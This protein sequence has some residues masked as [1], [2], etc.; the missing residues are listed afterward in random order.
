MKKLIMSVVSV[1]LA[2]TAFC[3]VTT[4][5]SLDC[6]D[7]A[8]VADTT[9]PLVY[10]ASWYTDGVTAKIMADGQEIV[11]GTT[12]TYAWVPSADGVNLLTLNVYNDSDEV[13]GT[14]SVFCLSREDLTDLVIP[15]GATEIDEYAF[16][17]G[18]FTSVM[19]P[20][21]VTNIA[22]TAFAGCEDMKTA[23]VQRKD[24]DLSVFPAGC[25]IIYD[26]DY[27]VTF[28]LGEHGK[29]VGGGELEQTVHHGDAA[30]SPE[31]E[32]EYGWAFVR[33]NADFSSILDNLKVSALWKEVWFEEK[34]GEMI[35]SYL[36][37]D[38]IAI[39]D[40]NGC[41]AVSG[42]VEGEVVVPATL[43]GYP[44]AAIGAGAF[45]GT[46]WI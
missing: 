17:G 46:A 26:I 9:H 38:G 16:A 14:E 27:V 31:V 37:K 32:A 22:S 5:L 3:A 36:L 8:K 29:R 19:I 10:D 24:Y 20:N 13:V 44:V 15:D 18:Q 33:W 1:L 23:T 39:V 2:G 34:V 45:S 21:S 43:G 11:S 7:G 12:G 25:Q 4:H 28:D 30:V 42:M 40:N 6:R 35:W 41:A